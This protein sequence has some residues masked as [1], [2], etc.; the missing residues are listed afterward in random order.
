MKFRKLVFIALISSCASKSARNAKMIYG[1][2]EQ[3][4]ENQNLSSEISYTAN[5]IIEYSE[6]KVR[7]ETECQ[8]SGFENYKAPVIKAVTETE[9]AYNFEKGIIQYLRSSKEERKMT[10][11]LKDLSPVDQL[12]ITKLYKNLGFNY[13][14]KQLKKMDFNFKCSSSIDEGYIKFDF[15]K[16]GDLILT[17][18][19]S[20]TTIK[21]L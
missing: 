20:S 5:A 16:N 9:V 4:N 6:N 12:K 13:S 2:Y 19:N 21:R 1:R 18:I 3:K 8:Y 14:A 10:L 11:L 7:I 17:P 15:N